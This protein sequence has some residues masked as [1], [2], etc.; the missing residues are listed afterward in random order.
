MVYRPSFL[1][2]LRH[3]AADRSGAVLIE[4]AFA[5]SLLLVMLVGIVT[6]GLWLMTANSLQQIANEAARSALGAMSAAERQELVDR[7]IAS[8]LLHTGAVVADRVT[9]S[10]ALDGDFFTVTLSYDATANA[11]FSATLIPLPADTIVRS[12]GIEIGGG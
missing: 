3:L 5:L 12:A 8:S 7:S 6:Y 4:A 9:V 2:R 11:I 10:T 1:S